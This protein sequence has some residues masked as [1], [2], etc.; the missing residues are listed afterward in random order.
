[1]INEMKEIGLDRMNV[2]I[3]ILDDKVTVTI[4]P[5]SGS[6]DEALL[7]LGGITLNGTIEEFSENSSISDKVLGL[8]SASALINEVEEYER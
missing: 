8:Q 5:I 3:T 7:N 2:S 4:V 6:N 1:M